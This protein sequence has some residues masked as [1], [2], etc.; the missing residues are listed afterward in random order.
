MRRLIWVTCFLGG[1][2]Q[3]SGQTI[4]YGP[5]TAYAG[6]V[7][8]KPFSAKFIELRWDPPRLPGAKPS[9]E[10]TGALYRDSQG[11]QRT[12]VELTL[13]SGDRVRMVGIFDAVAWKIYALDPATRTAIVRNL[14]ETKPDSS[15]QLEPGRVT[16]PADSTELV[17][18]IRCRVMKIAEG[19]GL[20]DTKGTA[21][22]SDDLQQVIKEELETPQVI[23]TWRLFDINQSE[24]DHELFKVPDDYVTIGNES[25]GRS[26]GTNKA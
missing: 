8:D 9:E 17:E 12:E 10:V 13:P 22:V 11:R 4:N 24:P 2:V 26:P 14:E 3:G 25:E 23:S 6:P 20:G 15:S 7:A 16:P 19:A 1:V 18:G 5:F 21:W